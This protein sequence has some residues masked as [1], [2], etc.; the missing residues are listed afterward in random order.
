MAAA[1]NRLRPQFP[2]LELGTGVVLYGSR[3]GML[4][5]HWRLAPDDLR[6]VGGSFPSGEGHPHPVVR[7]RRARPDGGADAVAEAG[8]LAVALEGAGETAFQVAADHGRYHAE[9]GLTNGDGGWLL[10]ARSNALDNVSPVGVSLVRRDSV[11]AMEA[12]QPPRPMKG[13]SGS[14]FSRDEALAACEVASR[15]TALAVPP[16]LHPSIGEGELDRAPGAIFTV[17]PLPPGPGMTSLGKHQ[18]PGPSG[19]VTIDDPEPALAVP[20]GPLVEVFPLV[21]VTGMDPAVTAPAL[22]G[23]AAVGAPPLM[24]LAGPLG[25]MQRA[26]AG[27]PLRLP[28]P[29]DPGAPA[30]APPPPV[31]TDPV[32]FAPVAPLVYGH[33]ASVVAGLKIEAELRI[34][35][36]AAPGS[37]IDL[38]GHP[39]RVGRG[40]RF[41]LM[42]RVDDPALLRQAL[43]LNPPPELALTRDP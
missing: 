27:R 32:T 35:G 2:S 42:V 19:L 41:Q 33:P 23:A 39:F 11:T 36:E 17:R 26:L 1:P 18:T 9:L 38:F 34:T 21:T 13:V 16:P 40:G 22:G 8:L 7:L 5:A 3:P 24:G 29:G 15:L 28:T 25:L 37:L 31:P 43:A 12:D 14:G 30:S 6:R 20:R 4:R 10:L